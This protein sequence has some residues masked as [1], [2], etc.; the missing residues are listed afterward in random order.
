MGSQVL[1]QCV[2]NIGIWYWLRHGIGIWYWVFGIWYR[3][4]VLGILHFLT[5]FLDMVFGLRLDSED[6]HSR[7]ME[8]PNLQRVIYEEHS[9]SGSQN[10]WEGSAF[11]RLSVSFHG[12]L[13]SW[14]TPFSA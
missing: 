5:R 12:L 3:F 14:Y 7:L 9:T 6:S 10:D 13:E 8:A 4:W 11:P 2:L 1:F